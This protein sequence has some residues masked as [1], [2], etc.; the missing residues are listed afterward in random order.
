MPILS[1]PKIKMASL[2]QFLF[3]LGLLYAGLCVFAFFFAERLMF[4]APAASYTL[5]TPGLLSIPTPNNPIPD[6]PA[7]YLSPPGNAFTLLYSHGNGED[8][9]HIAPRLEGLDAHGWDV[10][11]YDYPGYGATGGKA[12]EA[13]TYAAADA[14]FDYLTQT[15]GV[16][17]ERIVLYGRS[18]GGGPSFY[19]AEKHPNVAG[20]I[21][22]STFT[23]TYRVVTRAKLLPF[24]AFDNLA[25]IKHI[26]VPVLL[27]HGTADRIVPF[28]HGKQLL[29]VAPKGTRHAWFPGG[30]HNNLVED[31]SDTYWQAL[32][33]FH[34]HLL[35]PQ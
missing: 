3:A 26:N 7:R 11:A 20:L 27:L 18:L 15:L 10:F 29:D 14:A 9:G 28:S 17:P 1:M 21:T 13:N 23:S 24:D 22:E 12:T 4:P 5:K 8:L 32:E 30:D 33:T 2:A 25:R 34:K 6:L 16:P 19:L 31:Y 35:N